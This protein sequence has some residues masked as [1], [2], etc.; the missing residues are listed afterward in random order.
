MLHGLPAFILFGTLLVS[1]AATF[2]TMM[3]PIM[4]A[5][6]LL[7]TWILGMVILPSSMLK[8]EPQARPQ[9]WSNGILVQLAFGIDNTPPGGAI[10]KGPCKPRVPPEFPTTLVNRLLIA[11]EELQSSFLS[12]AVTIR[13]VVALTLIG[14]VSLESLAIAELETSTANSI[15]FEKFI[16]GFPGNIK[17]F[18]RRNASSKNQLLK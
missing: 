16:L 10:T 6:T 4:L 9:T 7:I 2:T 15:N 12:V 18:Q 1:S 11:N 5:G 8:K 14:Q 3:E 13:G 17:V